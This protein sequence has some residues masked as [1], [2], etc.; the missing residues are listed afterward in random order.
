MCCKHLFFFF[1]SNKSCSIVMAFAIKCYNSLTCMHRSTYGDSNMWYTAFLTLF[2]V[3]YIHIHA[4]YI[5]I[6]IYKKLC[7]DFFQAKIP[8][9][10]M[11][12]W[13]F[14]MELC[15]IVD[16]HTRFQTGVTRGTWKNLK[17]KK[18]I[19]FVCYLC[20]RSFMAQNINIA[21]FIWIFFVH[22]YQM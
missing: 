19:M 10:K 11:Q 20:F 13:W 8:V 2:F 1:W 18:I 16:L 17:K 21:F 5:Y 12:V 22:I 15:G 4:V 14:I 9:R 6:Y 7:S 3:L